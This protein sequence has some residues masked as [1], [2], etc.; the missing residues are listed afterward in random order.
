MQHI[1]R[2]MEELRRKLRSALS[3]PH[4]LAF[5]PAVVLGA[6]W[7]GGE[8][9][10]LIV[11]LGLP[12]LFGVAGGFTQWRP[13]LIDD[14]PPQLPD[15]LRDSLVRARRKD[16]HLGCFL[17]ALDDF[18]KLIDHHGRSV[19]QRISGRMVDRIGS[20]LRQGDYVLQRDAGEY[21]VVLA[22][23][24]QI[25]L[26]T[27]IQLARRLQSAIEDPISVDASSVYVSCSIGFVLDG[28]VGTP[29]SD[30][31]LDAAEAAL[32]DAR[33]N[34]PS[35]IRSY[36][37]GMKTVHRGHVEMAR[38]IERALETGQFQPWFQPQIS[39]DTGQVTGFEALARWIHP[40]RGVVPPSEFLPLLERCGL[41]ENLGEMMLTQSL[42]A[43]AKW[44]A[45]GVEVPRIGVN[46]AS[47]ELRNPKL[48][49]R[50]TWELDRLDLSPNRLSVEVLETVVSASPDDVIAR[51]INALAKLGCVIDLDDF[52]T[53]HSSIA[54]V[55]RFDV[56]RIKIDR[57]FVMKVDTD[58]EQ[59][60]MV[61]AIL[62]MADRLGLETVAEGVETAGEHAMLAQLGCTHVQGFGIARPMPFDQTLDWI[63]NND[64]KRKNTPRIGRRTG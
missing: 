25:D 43:L 46:F 2:A 16:L 56:R 47:A 23:V 3:G 51:N 60:K 30:D 41:I 39:T 34:G 28:Q 32:D 5:L 37:P 12:V 48:A 38:D 57:S 1:P 6:F 18:D 50:V 59:Q 33:S 36:A 55:R 22:P 64:I 61:A 62:T 58:P 11:S 42:L 52:G 45:S 15:L 9:W 8:V 10:L 21:A 7:L 13:A 4:I 53:G 54:S 35:A 40:H 24:R 29:Q 17:L 14:S 20:A 49:D 27:A 19:A 44:D 31:L 63:R 26:E